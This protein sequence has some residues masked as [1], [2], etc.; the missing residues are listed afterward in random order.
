MCISFLKRNSS[1]KKLCFIEK[2]LQKAELIANCIRQSYTL[3]TQNT[4]QTI[5]PSKINRSVFISYASEDK[6]IADNLCSKLENK[7]IKVWYAPR[8]VRGA[9]ANAIVKAI[10]S[11]SYFIVILSQNSIGSEH[12]LSEIDLAFQNLPNNIKFKPLRID[13]AIF[14]PSFKSVW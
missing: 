10:D 12:V 1:V 4:I 9:Y 13:D 8:D 6:N 11:A 2:S 14:T 5:G 3:L 7:G